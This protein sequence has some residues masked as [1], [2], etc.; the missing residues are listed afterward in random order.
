MMLVIIFSNVGMPNNNIV[1][2]YQATFRQFEKVFSGRYLKSFVFP[3][4]L[5][6]DEPGSP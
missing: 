2:L 4:A 3:V 5:Q 1:Q 6:G